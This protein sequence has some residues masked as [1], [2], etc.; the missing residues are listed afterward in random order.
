MF[1]ISR[2]WYV[3]VFLFLNYCGD[4]EA[5]QVSC[6][7]DSWVSGSKTLSASSSKDSLLIHQNPFFPLVGKVWYQSLLSLLIDRN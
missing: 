6:S 4:S 1:D 2:I 5:T 7:E 3:L